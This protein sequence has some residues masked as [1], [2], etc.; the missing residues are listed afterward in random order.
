MSVD[1]PKETKIRKSIQ[2]P[3]RKQDPKPTPELKQQ[4]K[5]GRN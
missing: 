1:E 4:P 5:S 3:M 2:T